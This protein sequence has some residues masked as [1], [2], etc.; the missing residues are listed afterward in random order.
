MKKIII[1]KKLGSHENFLS[2]DTKYSNNPEVVLF[3]R[4]KSIPIDIFLKS[5]NLTHE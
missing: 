1:R 4:K 3:S 5:F 2:S